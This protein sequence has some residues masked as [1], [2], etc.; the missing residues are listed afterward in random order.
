MRPRMIDFDNTN[1][2][3]PD[4]WKFLSICP[5]LSLALLLWVVDSDL[6]LTVFW[7]LLFPVYRI[8]GEGKTFPLFRDLSQSPDKKRRSWNTCSSLRDDCF[9]GRWCSAPTLTLWHFCACHPLPTIIYTWSTN[10][11]RC[12]LMQIVTTGTAYS[13]SSPRPAFFHCWPEAQ[14]PP[15]I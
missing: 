8:G 7:I 12:Q 15:T 1:D 2:C 9:D 14:R 5:L 4:K 11:I 13:P 6:H 3:L 10:P